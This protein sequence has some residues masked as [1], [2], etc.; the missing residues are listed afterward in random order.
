MGPQQIEAL[1]VKKD[2]ELVQWVMT[3]FW[4]AEEIEKLERLIVCIFE[5]GREYERMPSERA[6]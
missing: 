6:P 1:L 5:A 3:L 4:Q 2:R